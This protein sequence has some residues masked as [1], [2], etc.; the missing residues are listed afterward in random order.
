V[1]LAV[2]D[3]CE[4]VEG[5]VRDLLVVVMQP[6][7]GVLPDFGQV[8]EHVE[9]EHA[10]AVAAVETFDEAVL[11]RSAGLDELEFN[12]LGFRP[13]GQRNGD[14]LG[15]VIQPQ[16]LRIAAPG[17]NPIQ[18]ADDPASGKV[19][20][21]LDRQGLA[22]VVVNDVEGAESAAIPERIRHE[23]GRP[24]GIDPLAHSQRLRMPRG[25][26]LLAAPA[27]IQPQLAVHPIHPLV[28]P[29]KTTPPTIQSQLSCFWT[30]TVA[31]STAE[32]VQIR[33]W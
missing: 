28:I 18:R 7:L 3:G 26:P 10:F 25:N 24:A 13:L 20:V 4:P 29:V 2:L 31:T 8:A 9:V 12:A 5:V 21:D 19:Q 33:R 11:H 6:A 27:T 15:A 23:V 14:E 32:P 16:S 22:V 30:M 1:E 17:S